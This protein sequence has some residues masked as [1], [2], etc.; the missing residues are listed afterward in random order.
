M[1][2]PANFSAISE[3][4]LTYVAGGAAL[5]DILAPALTEANWQTFNTNMVR[6]IGNK[7]VQGFVNSTLGVVF[8]GEYIPGD[9][10]VG[11]FK[12]LKNTIGAIA[13]NEDAKW[14]DKAA[15]YSLLNLNGAL[16]AIGNLAAVYNLATGSVENKLPSSWN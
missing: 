15:A 16:N 4:E 6:L 12:S 3:N 1:M 5:E 2:M 7:Y 10:L 9:A 11:N 8:S 14:T 13:H